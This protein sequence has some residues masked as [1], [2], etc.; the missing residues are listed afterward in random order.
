METYDP[1]INCAINWN[2]ANKSDITY[3][4]YN[5]IKCSE[6]SAQNAAVYD[7]C[8]NKVLRGEV[9]ILFRKISETVEEVCR[10]KFSNLE[11][12]N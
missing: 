8:K 7:Q 5:S 9:S 11:N 12:K 6:Y 1:K 2:V 3:E 4:G 10:C